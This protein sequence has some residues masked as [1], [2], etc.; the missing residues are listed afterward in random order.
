M[1]TA[2]HML[3]SIVN[4]IY[5]N[6]CS[7]THINQLLNTFRFGKFKKQSQKE[8]KKMQV[9]TPAG[10][11]IS[12]EASTTATPDSCAISPS[13]LSAGANV[14]SANAWSWRRQ[15]Q[16]TRTHLDSGASDHSGS[17]VSL[18]P[19]SPFTP[20][21]TPMSPPVA[22][23]SIRSPPIFSAASPLPSATLTATPPVVPFQAVLEEEERL[24]R[25]ARLAASKSAVKPSL[26]L[27][28]VSRILE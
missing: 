5:R 17:G 4:L 12:I 21:P 27:I 19:I 2:S 15:Q 3:F 1:H 25:A 11:S 20:T 18:T 6:L 23:A 26:N 16:G 8:H 14:T 22:H 7:E 9:L 24:E 28:A 10:R 13:A